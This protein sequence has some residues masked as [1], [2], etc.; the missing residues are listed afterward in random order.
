DSAK[1]STLANADCLLI[2]APNAPAI[3]K[4]T[5]VKIMLLRP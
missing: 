3:T 5:Q 1:L 4:G 2:R